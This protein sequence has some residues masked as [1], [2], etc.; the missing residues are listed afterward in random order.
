MT[1][2]STMKQTLL[3]GLTVGL[4]LLLFVLCGCGNTKSQREDVL[5]GCESGTTDKAEKMWDC[6]LSIYI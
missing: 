2:K 6:Y 4:F 1:E 3:G 5:S